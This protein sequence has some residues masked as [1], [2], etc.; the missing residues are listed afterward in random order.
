MLYMTLLRD[1]QEGVSHHS[2]H[3]VKVNKVGEA[4]SFV[5]CLSSRELCHYK[6]TGTLGDLEFNIQHYRRFAF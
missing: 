6:I 3:S 5:L 2:H 4:N 1:K